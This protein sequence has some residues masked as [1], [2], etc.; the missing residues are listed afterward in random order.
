MLLELLDRATQGRLRDMQ[1]RGGTAEVQLLGYGE[2]RA[3]LL[4]VH[5]PSFIA[6]IIKTEVPIKYWT[7]GNAV[8]D[9]CPMDTLNPDVPD[10]VF[11]DVLKQ[12]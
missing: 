10:D 8:T 7:D 12:I 4:D 2:E 9:S 1:A 11:A 5:L 3:E 6:E